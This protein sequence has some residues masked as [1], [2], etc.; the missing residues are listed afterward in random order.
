MDRQAI[1]AFVARDRASVDRLKRQHWIH[2]FRR[3]G[4]AATVSAARALWEHARSVR[5]DWPGADDRAA[6]LTHHIELKRQLD[7]IADAFTSR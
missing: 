1:E 4:A 7:R 5:P 2:A 3:C 6:D